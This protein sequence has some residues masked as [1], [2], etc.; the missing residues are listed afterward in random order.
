MTTKVT[1]SVIGTDTITASNIAAD[2]V[3]SSE[4]AADAVGA[5]EIAAGAVGTSEIADGTVTATDLASSL[6]LSGKTLVLSAAQKASDFIEVRDE[7]AA[8][9]AGGGF[10]SGAWQTRDLN[11]EASD[12]GNNASVASNQITL[13]AG[14]YECCITAPAAFVNAHK[15]KLYNVTDAADV[16]IGSSEWSGTGATIQTTSRV[17]GK[18]TIAATKVFEVRHRCSTTKATDGYGIASNFGVN[19]VYTIARFWKVG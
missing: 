3:G 13:A 9:T 18:F 8:N 17:T 5:S 12:T 7:K 6:D 4:I 14:T 10:T 16:L 1:S 15:A 19:E 11:T 2:A